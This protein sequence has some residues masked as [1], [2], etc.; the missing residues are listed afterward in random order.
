VTANKSNNFGQ[1]AKLGIALRTVTAVDGKIIPISASKY[2]EG[3]DK[4]TAS[5][6]LGLLCCFL[7]LFMHGG[8]TT[9][10]AGT[11]INATTSMMVDIDS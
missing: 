10:P 9:I 6:G 1:P 2:T 4:Q 8:E 5:L 3:E 7:L 11:L